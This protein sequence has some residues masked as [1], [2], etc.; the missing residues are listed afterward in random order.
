MITKT[1]V[2][3]LREIAQAVADE[4]PAFFEVKGAGLGNKDSNEF[5]NEVRRRALTTFG[6]DYAEKRICGSTAHAVDFYFQDDATIVE[7]ALTLKNPAPEFEKDILKALMA[8]AENY[9][10]TSLVFISKPGAIKKCSSPGRSAIRQWALKH[11]NLTI[12]IHEINNIHPLNPITDV[13]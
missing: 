4:R 10:V 7:I 3:L 8:Q 9:P 1:K 11:H 13:N 12:E 2:E 6:V 5:M